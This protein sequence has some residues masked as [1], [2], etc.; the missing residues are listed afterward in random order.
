LHPNIDVH[1]TNSVLEVDFDRDFVDVAI[2]FGDGKWPGTQTD[3][4]FRDEIEPVCSPRF[5]SEHASDKRHPER[6]L[7]QRLLVSHFRAT[8]WDDWL[9][10]TGLA[11]HATDVERMRFSTSVLTGRRR[12]TGWALRLVSLHS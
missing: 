10:A 5:L 7:K 8:D 11:S 12:W 2:Q 3:L 1:I 6:L 9:S 4:L